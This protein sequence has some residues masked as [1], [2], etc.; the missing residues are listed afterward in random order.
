LRAE[1]ERLCAEQEHLRAEQ[2]RLHR[3]RDSHERAF[4]AARARAFELDASFNRAKG[5]LD[6]LRRSFSWRVTSPIRS[7]WR[8]LKRAAGSNGS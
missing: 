5:E 2:E 1:Q 3:E 4:V 7:L 6:D 8:F